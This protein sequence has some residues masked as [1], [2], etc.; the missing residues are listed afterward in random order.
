MALGTLGGSGVSS[1]RRGHV[2][3]IFACRGGSMHPVFHRP[4]YTFVQISG[5]LRS[6][7]VEPELGW[8]ISEVS[9][10]SQVLDHKVVGTEV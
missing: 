7:A 5:H 10:C 6:L 2:V 9:I 1:E 4:F 8:I 3:S